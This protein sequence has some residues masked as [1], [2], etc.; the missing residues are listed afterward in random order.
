MQDIN[1]G[2]FFMSL[3]HFIE[4]SGDMGYCGPKSSFGSKWLNFGEDKFIILRPGKCTRHV[5]VSLKAHLVAQS[6]DKIN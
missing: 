1:D 4:Y 3:D 5:G 2:I 6:F